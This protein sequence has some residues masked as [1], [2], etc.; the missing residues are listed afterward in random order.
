MPEFA[1]SEL[2]VTRLSQTPD[3]LG[4]SP[5]WDADANCLWWIDGVAGIIRRRRFKPDAMVES[6]VIGGHIGAIALASD[7][8]LVVA[9]RHEFLL[10]DPA[11]QAC[12]LVLRLDDADP[13]MRLNDGKLDRQGRLIC[14]GMGRPDHPL[15]QVHQVDHAGQH[16]ILASGL[17]IGNGVCFSPDGR[18]LYFSDTRARKLFICDYDPITGHTG[19][20]SL[21][22]DTAPFGSGIDGATVDRDGNLWVAFIHSAEIACFSPDR[23]L[24][25]RFAAP[26]DYP[27]SLT[28][29]G[30]DLQTLFVTS[31]R[32]SGTGRA[33]SQH[34]DG[35][36]IFAITGTGASGLPEAR[37]QFIPDVEPTG[38][39][40]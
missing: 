17:Q 16:R 2:T 20:E 33:I 7:G 4:E 40:R 27:S 37:F 19:A 13:E 29:G 38:K 6:F 22:L 9:R 35:G 26:M 8:R 21:H 25:G 18:T 28:F 24:L 23:T 11:S 34:P 36:H 15:G 1:V 30:P 12:S 10:F 3:A 32:D 39:P 14:A 31:I 5:V